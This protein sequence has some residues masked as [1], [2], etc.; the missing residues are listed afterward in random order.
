MFKIPNK[1]ADVFILSIDPEKEQIEY[2]VRDKDT[3]VLVEPLRT[4][5][6]VINEADRMVHFDARFVSLDIFQ[7][8]YQVLS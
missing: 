3:G 4:T 6:F 1:F 5:K 7:R 8:A 2:T